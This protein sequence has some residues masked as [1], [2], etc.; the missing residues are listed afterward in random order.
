MYLGFSCS[1]VLDVTEELT[2]VATKKVP[3]LRFKLTAVVFITLFLETLFLS[4]G[5]TMENAFI[6]HGPIVL[7]SYQNSKQLPGISSVRRKH[8]TREIFARSME[9]YRASSRFD[10]PRK[11]RHPPFS[12]WTPKSNSEKR[13]REPK[14]SD[15]SEISS[16]EQRHR[17]TM[18]LLNAL[19]EMNI[20]SQE[21]C[22]FLIRCSRVRVNGVVTTD[23]K[24]RVHREGDRISVN[25]RDIGTVDHGTDFVDQWQH[26]IPRT[27][28]DRSPSEIES[29]QRVFNRHTD[30]GFFQSKKY[31]SGK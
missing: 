13:V 9:S 6:P 27:H 19:V 16:A 8:P 24:A 3:H 22:A 4:Y 25:G 12:S 2:V 21:T 20:S 10:K 26:R 18:T 29:L 15:K 11:S 23:E 7:R 30:G 5:L 1:P 28:R 31:R 17:P 14:Q